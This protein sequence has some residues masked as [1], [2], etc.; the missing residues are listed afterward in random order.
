MNTRR[1]FWHVGDNLS[2]QVLK[3]VMVVANWLYLTNDPLHCIAQI[4]HERYKILKLT[5]R[6]TTLKQMNEHW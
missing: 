1:G 4:P 6:Y 5:M 2:M 3:M